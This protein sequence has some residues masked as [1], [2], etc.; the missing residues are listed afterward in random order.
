MIRRF[1][2]GRDRTTDIPVADESVSRFH[3]EIWL[4]PDGELVLA[5]R[6]SSNGTE[7][8]RNG[9]ISQL[10]QGAVLPTDE[11][12]LGAA[13]FVVKDLIEAIEL[14][15]PGGLTRL[16][17]HAA[18]ATFAPPP[19]PSPAP[20]SQAPAGFSIRHP[21]AP[22]PLPSPPAVPAGI[23]SGVE[24]QYPPV[25]PPLPPTPPGIASGAAGRYPPAAAHP[26]IPP[27]FSSPPPLPGSAQ[28]S[29]RG[30]DNSLVR[31]DCGALKTQGQACP[32]CYKVTS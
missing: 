2:I 17:E 4:T 12:R 31:C 11:V 15:Y 13:T 27:P 24:V 21:A 16:P 14:K 9:Q 3:A 28:S 25:P 23:P 6:G 7:L 22:P 30:A 19:L 32:R 8:I 18:A 10:T 1:T 26:P 20:A 5:D 29:P